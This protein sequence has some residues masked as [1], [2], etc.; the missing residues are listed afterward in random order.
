MLASA[1]YQ[2]STASN[3]VTGCFFMRNDCQFAVAETF[4]SPGHSYH[5]SLADLSFSSSQHPSS[6]IVVEVSLPAIR[7]SN[8]IE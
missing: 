1:S 3:P 2:L 4:S 5:A 8:V 6:F 7:E